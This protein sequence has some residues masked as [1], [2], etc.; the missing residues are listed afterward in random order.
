MLSSVADRQDLVPNRTT[1]AQGGETSLH[2]DWRRI[3]LFICPIYI[4]RPAFFNLLN[5]LNGR[6]PQNIDISIALISKTYCEETKISTPGN[7]K[8]NCPPQIFYSTVKF[9]FK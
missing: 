3:F 9:E 6:R 7:G 1:N 8:G 5:P 2:C 4:R